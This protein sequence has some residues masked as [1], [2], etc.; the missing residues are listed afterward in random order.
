MWEMRFSWPRV[1]CFAVFVLNDSL[2]KLILNDSIVLLRD[3][4]WLKSSRE[5]LSLLWQSVKS[6]GRVAWHSFHGSLTSYRPSLNVISSLNLS[7]TDFSSGEIPMAS[8][9][10]NSA[11]FLS[12][13]RFSELS[14][15]NCSWVSTRSAWVFVKLT[16]VEF[17]VDPP[18]TGPESTQPTLVCRAVGPLSPRLIAPVRKCQ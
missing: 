16:C 9:S 11:S 1:R 2:V 6:S 17:N 3:F 7:Y 15:M 12:K 4:F 18:W 8:K 10:Q 5:R 13:A 14:S